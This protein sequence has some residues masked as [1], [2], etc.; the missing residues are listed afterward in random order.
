VA[1]PQWRLNSAPY[2]RH[3]RRIPTKTC[4]EQA[5]THSFCRALLAVLI[6]PRAED[7]RLQPGKGGPGISLPEARTPARKPTPGRFAVAMAG[8]VAFG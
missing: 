8:G 3:A 2:E 6:V 7:M 4:S 1:D 5:S